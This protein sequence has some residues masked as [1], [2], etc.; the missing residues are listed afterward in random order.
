[1][2][3]LELQERH[4]FDAGLETCQYDGSQRIPDKELELIF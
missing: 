4:Y 1:M 3:Y 2:V